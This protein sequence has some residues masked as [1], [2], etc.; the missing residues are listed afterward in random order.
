MHPNRWCWST[1]R[2]RR[3]G[4]RTSRRCTARARPGTSASPA[5]ASTA[6]AGCW[7]PSARGTSGRSRC[8]GPTPAAGI[9]PRASAREH[10][11]HRRLR[12]ELGLRATDLRLVLPDFSYRASLHGIE[13]NELCPVFVCVLDGDPRPDPTEVEDWQ[14]WPWERFLDECRRP[15]Q[16]AVAVG[17]DAGPAARRAGRSAARRGR[18][19]DGGRPAPPAGGRGRRGADR[20]DRRAAAG[21]LRHRLHGARPPGGAVAAAAGGAPRRRGR[22][23]PAAGRGER[24]RSRR[25]AGPPPGCGCSTRGCARSPSSTATPGP[26]THG[27]P[28]S[29]LFDQ[30]DLDALLRAAAERAG[31]ALRGGVEV[32]GVAAR[33]DGTVAVTARDPATGA[34]ADAAAPP[35][36]SAAT[37]PTAPS[38]RRSGPACGTWAS[39]SAG[40]CWTSA[41]RSIDRRVGRRRPG[42]RS[43]PGRHLHAPHRRPVPLGVP[44]APG[45]VGRGTGRPE[46]VAALTAPWFA[47][48]P[49]ARPAS[50]CAAPSTRSGRASPTAG[51]PAGCCCSATPPTSRRRSSGRVSGAGLRDAHNLAWKLAAVLQGRAG[52]DLLDSYQAERA[53]QAEAT[54]RTAVR[55]G[56]AMTGGNG[57][58]AALRR[59]LVAALL[60][61]PGAETRALAATTTPSPGRRRRRPP[62]APPGSRGHMLPAAVR[63]VR[64]RPPCGWTRSSA[65]GSRC[66]TRRRWMPATALPGRAVG[67]PHGTAGRP[68]GRHDDADITIAD[69]RHRSRAGCVAAGPTRCCCGPTGWSWPARPRRPESLRAG[70]HRGAVEYSPSRCSDGGAGRGAGGVRAHDLAD[71]EV[72][73]SPSGSTHCRS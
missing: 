64:R 54:I 35:P 18:V 60:R 21:P 39:P 11:V 49:D 1:T 37:G 67:G 55:V 26:A 38:A 58:V 19:T 56:R 61:L 32:T 7:S 48:A 31:V 47:G 29:N 12:D 8:C 44:A 46:S 70:S 42:L 2:A 16:R 57:A 9:P 24:R 28:A 45:R 71:Y 20:A 63:P 65:P 27:H 36:C 69:D 41:A 68:G 62:P 3:S 52:D 33:A 17:P 59:P 13:E 34:A 51:G 10:A 53:P 23:R 4:W 30:R 40:W 6:P 5:T 66:C 43:A 25:S 50:C 72:A 15:G 22:A 14:W 73:I